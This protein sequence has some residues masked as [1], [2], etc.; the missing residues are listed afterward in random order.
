MAT[1]IKMMKLITEAD[2]L[3]EIEKAPPKPA[4]YMMQIRP[5]V[6]KP[7]V[8]KRRLPIRIMPGESMTEQPVPI[9]FIKPENK[10]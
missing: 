4:L 8:P 5:R 10:A 9:V 1:K 3:G 2:A 7:T 6:F